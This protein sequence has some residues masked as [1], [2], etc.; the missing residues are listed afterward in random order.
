MIFNEA[1]FY[2]A[3]PVSDIKIPEHYN[4]LAYR[5]LPESVPKFSFGPVLGLPPNPGTPNL[6]LGDV[7]ESRFSQSPVISLL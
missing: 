4:N 6:K 7:G 3:L 1:V 5:G 2:F